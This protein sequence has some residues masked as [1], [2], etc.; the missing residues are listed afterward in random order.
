MSIQIIRYANVQA[1]RRG[2]ADESHIDIQ[3]DCGHSLVKHRFLAGSETCRFL[4]A[5]DDYEM[6][7]KFNGGHYC[8]MDGVL[9]SFRYSDYNG[10]LHSDDSIAT[11]SEV[12]GIDRDGN[13]KS[14]RLI[15]S[16]I[17]LG[18]AGESFG[19]RVSGLGDGGEFDA[20]LVYN[21]SPFSDR[22]SCA[23]EMVRLVCDNG[24]VSRSRVLTR[25][26]RIINDWQ[27]NLGVVSTQ[28]RP[29]I[30]DFIQN[31]YTEMVKERATL[32]E[33]NSA[34]SVLTNRVCKGNTY[35][36][37]AR[38][39]RLINVVDVRSRI[40]QYK[41]VP[42]SKTS[43]IITD[44]TRYDVVNV[45]TEAFSHVESSVSNNNSIQ[46]AINKMVTNRN[47]IIVDSSSVKS[48]QDGDHSIAFFGAD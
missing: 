32:S 35:E 38:L 1:S 41:G 9:V 23:T 24:M 12:L 42:T 45:L 31:R 33:T 29:I 40:D 7:R 39:E 28:M 18:G 34:L 11:L 5:F 27:R 36:E 19:V 48:Y 46:G 21:W 44:L 17:F 37:K 26:V 10:F 14:S 13:T 3:I 25:E 8:I 30:T 47:K 43:S 4:S 6:A 2:F 15:D 16:P 22:I 20:N